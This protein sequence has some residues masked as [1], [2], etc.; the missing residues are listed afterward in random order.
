MKLWA[1]IPI[2][3][4]S[5][6]I[7]S[8]EEETSV[9]NPTLPLKS[10]EYR[11]YQDKL[12][13][14]NIPVEINVKDIENRINKEFGK[15]IYED[16]SFEDNGVDD[17]KIKVKKR[18]NIKIGTQNGVAKVAIPLTI[19]AAKR[20]KK[21]VF[22]QVISYTNDTEF[23]ITIRYTVQL[24]IKENWVLETETKGD[25]K[26]DKK[27]YVN[28][29][30]VDIPIESQVKKP[31]DDQVIEIAK[32][33][34][35][36]IQ[37]TVNIREI[38]TMAWEQAHEPM[39]MDSLT[40][41]WLYIKPQSVSATQLV[42]ID[43]KA[44]FG[45][46][47]TTFV[48]NTIGEPKQTFDI[49]PLPDLELVD[50][51]ADDFNVALS[52]NASYENI[53]GL[54]GGQF[55]GQ[56]F[57]FEKDEQWITVNDIDLWGSAENLVIKLD[58]KGRFKQGI[59]KKKVKG[60]LF[61]EGTP[62]FDSTTQEIKIKDLEFNLETKDLLIKMAKWFSGKKIRKMMEENLVF[63]VKDQLGDAKKM[64]EK[65]LEHYVINDFVTLNGTLSDL[66]PE[67][68]FLSD[69]AVKVIVSAKGKV[70]MT[71]SGF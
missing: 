5:N 44:T 20:L 49:P 22:G 71:A 31:L 55:K 51:I 62:Y 25:F 66:Q 1:I 47:I 48:Q 21:S 36:N 10:T 58:V 46:G 52:A 57:E 37:E 17:L 63:S 39:Q 70:N 29:I 40:N 9:I 7:M 4:F 27:P 19:W 15:V 56:T 53:K 2:L 41:A 65:Q 26:W 33:I 11:V 61:L 8:Q 24:K 3:L 45:L 54:L 60:I 38:G 16:M 34:D 23:D 68:I 12:S 13:V 35:K 43:N 18:S 69:T 64:I 6:F 50:S 32:L 14:I 28:V 42:L 59:I 30:G 67:G